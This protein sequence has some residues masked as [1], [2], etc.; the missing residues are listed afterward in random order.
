MTIPQTISEIDKLRADLE[1]Y[2]WLLTD[3]Y[4]D[5][6]IARARIATL[7]SQRDTWRAESGR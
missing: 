7:Q 2:K 6:A 4:A 5:L 3:A 1:A